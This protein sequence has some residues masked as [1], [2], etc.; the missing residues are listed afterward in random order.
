[1]RQF[2]SNTFVCFIDI[3]GFKNE[4]QK[5]INSAGKML[6]VF[7]SAGY[8]T[9]KKHKSLNGI[10]VSDCGIIY[11]DKGKNFSKLNDILSAIKE[12][13]QKML[14]EN[15]LTTASIAYGYLEYKKKFVFD[16]IKKN[17]IVGSGYL[18]AFLDN[19]YVIP[20][21]RPGE[22]RITKNLNGILSS[23]DIFENLDYTNKNLNFLTN[24]NTHLYFNWLCEDKKK[25]QNV[26]FIY[27]QYDID[28]TNEKYENLK[29][30]LKEL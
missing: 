28:L 1:M 19:E 25:L 11:S 8:N 15:Y 26:D 4:L 27:S 5:D 16:R 21:L 12:I 29:K 30:R 24:T 7:Y 20:K 10:F 13:N 17:A 9:L 14:S 18:N 23:N 2:N 6:D 3:S 22:V